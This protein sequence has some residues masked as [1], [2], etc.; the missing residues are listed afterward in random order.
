MKA[1]YFKTATLVVILLLSSITSCIKDLDTIPLDKD[2]MVS[3]RVYSNPANYRLLLAKL[4]GG[5]AMS[6]QGGPHQDP[7]LTGLDSGFGQY[8]RALWYA[9]ELPTDEAII[10]WNDRTIKDYHAQSWSSSDVF[11]QNMYYRI[12]YQITI[13][14][15]FIR[16]TTDSKLSARGFTDAQVAE[17]KT[18]RAEA[19]FL[20]AL[21]YYH[22]I[23]LF[24]NVPF[25]TEENT[26]GSFF[27]E[28]KDR[29]FLFNYVE[30]EL[31]AIEND[32][33]PA[34]Q[35]EY[36]RA[37][38][39]ADWMVLA[40][41]YQN[42]KVYL[43]ES[44]EAE[45]NTNCLTYC[46]KIIAAGYSLHPEFNQLFMAD[47]GPSNCNDEIIFPIAFD[48]DSTQNWGGTTFIIA[49]SIGGSM[50]PSDYGTASSWSGLRTTKQ[51][52]SKFMDISGLKSATVKKNLKNGYPV[53]YMPGS[54][55]TGMGAA[56]NWDPANT[57]TVIKSVLSD[58]NYE[59]Y[60]YFADAGA[61]FKI[62]DGPDWTTNYGD[63]G[64]DGTLDLNGANI[65]VAT[66]GYYK[67]NVDFNAKTYTLLKTDW[68]IIG[69]APAPYDWSADQ[70][71]T[72]DAANGVWT[73]IAE[74]HA[75]EF[76]FRGNHDWSLNYGDNGADGI[77]EAGGS[78]IAIPSQRKYKITL[79][80]GA[81]D[82]TYTIEPYSVDKR[83]MFWSNGQNLEINDVGEFTDGW[84]V[85]KF[86]NMTS[87]GVA[88]SNSTFMDTDFPMFRLADV[89]LMY[90]EAVLRGG[91]G[92]DATTA[93]GYVNDLK[94][95]A[96]GDSN[97]NITADQLTLDFILDERARE[98]L[99]EC[100]R[101]QDLIR[102]GKFSDTDY[103][104]AWK[105]GVKDGKAV[106]NH[107]DL[108]PIP[109]ADMV[110]NPTLKQND[111]Y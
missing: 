87:T 68:G 77:L 83:I 11:I 101:R 35:N 66:A 91:T 22:A 111:G 6:G 43:P 16:E 110:A 80:L 63:D 85:I 17:I 67:V 104:W 1:K 88:G 65:V 34:R 90:A 18:F 9:Q 31:L 79:K 33:V 96:Y 29:A 89:Y 71:M 48:G 41:L 82:Y 100:H 61:L 47:N 98:L 54:Y 52:V 64:A 72:Y 109:A 3:E 92:G 14:N 15:E 86:T 106:D 62:C 73:I 40:K 75:G 32:L 105:G 84:T 59:G 74:L 49:A 60:L 76:K 5:L 7:D 10:S 36:A 99:F 57:T 28:Q 81:P 93:L 55:Q 50:I 38:Q 56:A 2:V 44:N 37:D 78:N 45:N 13:C 103:L 70:D 95:R 20:R 108:F 58:G 94:E 39:A 51:L 27:P 19:R 46:N 102:F 69:S 8:L 21:S 26:V 30:S 97:G 24:G 107:Y 23:D 42:E 12:Y 4:Y 53:L 25:I